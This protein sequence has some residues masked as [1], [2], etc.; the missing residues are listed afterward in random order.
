MKHIGQKIRT[1]RIQKG[2]GLNAL[3]GKLEVSPA[4]LS[5]LETGKTETIHLEFL[6]RLQKELNCTPM[7]LFTEVNSSLSQDYSEFD[8]RMERSKQLLKQ[9]QQTEP[10]FADYLLA[11]M[12]KG[13]DL[14]SKKELLQPEEQI[15]DCD[16]H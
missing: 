14:Y 1:I 6:E 9:L 12:E 5:N 4:Y 16:Y 11:V 8:Y 3:A 13:L 7:D 10:K 2:I 15:K